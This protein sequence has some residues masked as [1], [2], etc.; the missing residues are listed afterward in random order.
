MKDN[1][2]KDKQNKTE[3][4]N[5]TI[6]LMEVYSPKR[7]IAPAMSRNEYRQEEV[8]SKARPA[9]IYDMQPVKQRRE[10]FNEWLNRKFYIPMKEFFE[11]DV[12]E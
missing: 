1:N 4:L 6:K 12:E 9:M 8:M 2:D 11:K 7:G 3:S 10:T 5:K